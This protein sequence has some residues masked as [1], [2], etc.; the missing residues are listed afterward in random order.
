MITTLT[1]LD[2][3]FSAGVVTPAITD[4]PDSIEVYEGQTA[5]FT[6]AA[7]GGGLSYQWQKSDNAGV[8][9]SNISGATSSSYTTAATVRTT[10]NDD[11]FR[12]VVT[13][14]AGTVNSNAA[15]LTVWSPAALT[16]LQLWL[17][18]SDAATVLEGTADTAEAND[19]V[20]Q[21]SDK[22]GNA[23]HAT[24]GTLAARPVY[25]SAAQN[26]RNV[27][28]WD[29]A[30]DFLTTG[31]ASTFN[32]LHNGTSSL[33][34]IVARPGLVSNPNAIYAFID[35]CGISSGSI[36]YSLAYDDRASVPRNNVLFEQVSRGVLGNP[37]ISNLS[38]DAWTPNVFSIIDDCM[39]A[40]NATAAN[41]SKV[42]INNG[43]E[44]ANNILTNA[45]STSN[46][47]A[48]MRI[49]SSSSGTFFLAGQI[50][51][52]IICND[53]NVSLLAKLRGYLAWKWGVTIA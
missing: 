39:D 9:W 20:S 35:N 49:G 36:G 5:T 37:S 44:I 45:P 22:S 51:E 27:I 43:T 17:D 29:G 23:R 11:Q 30:D 32:H 2:V 38:G 3:G 12:C 40:D 31:A 8:D 52:V 1:P 46:A 7:T 50:A 18:A 47:T 4:Q 16:G 26:G 13:N 10:D 14:T 41:R 25:R 53:Q 34:C 21:W 28:E 24:Q 6:V 19:P 48:S 15:T 33:V 42:R